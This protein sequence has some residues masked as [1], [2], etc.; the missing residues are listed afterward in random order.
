MKLTLREV[1]EESLA[2][3]V[4]AWIHEPYR[5]IGMM[6]SLSGS[7]LALLMLD[8][9]SNAAELWISAVKDG[10]YSSLTPRV[11]QLHWQE[12][13]IWDMFGILPDAHPRL[14]HVRLHE[15]YG[16]LSPPLN[17]LG[18]VTPSN[19]CRYD[20]MEVAGVGVYEIPVGPIH[21]G[22]IEPGHFRFSC[23]GEVIANLEI[24]LGYVHRGIESRLTVVPWQRARFIVESVASDCS[25]AYGLAHA[26]AIE[27]LL[28][29][30]ISAF[31]NGI[32][33]LSLEIE[34]VAM[35]IC[36]L[37]GIAGDVG[38][39]PIASAFGRLR[40]D[41]LRLGELLSGTR[42]QRFFIRPGG[43]SRK[44]ADGLVEL[45]R[46]SRKL[47]QDLRPVT[48]M[49]MDNSVAL[50]RMKG[51]GKVTS[52]L[53]RDF[54]MVGV[55]GRASGINY[56]VRDSFPSPATEYYNCVPRVHADGDVFARVMIRVEEAH[57]SLKMIDALCQQ[58]P[59]ADSETVIAL[60]E[61]LPPDE[62]AMSIVESHRGELLHLVATDAMGR[63]S[64]YAIKDPSVNNW[65]GLA[66][67]ARDNLVADFPL[68]NKSFS[69]SYSGH[70]L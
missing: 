31:E 41:A 33:A 27:S 47:G 53:A 45:L 67:A 43:G 64:R 24:R 69:L 12:R 25:A 1:P 28:G 57:A 38:F 66:I 40:G 26:Q 63:I 46:L 51:V 37:G 61:F 2:S 39:L 10:E 3:R 62:F 34:R 9:E 22:I 23:L 59:S 17:R 56:D 20:F 58:L 60:P 70:D 44:N 42:L 4:S 55:A 68:C 52:S 16:Q 8:P 29:I 32:R 49:L 11:P 35:H 15:P 30:D 5:R 36:D 6:T 50:E 48:D 21:A 13:L 18:A 19:G 7:E 65:T 14:K 54:G